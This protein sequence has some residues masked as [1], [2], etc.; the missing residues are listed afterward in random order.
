[1]TQVA[2]ATFAEVFAAALRGTPAHVVGLHPADHPLPVDG[3]SAAAEA[4]D[5]TLLAHCLGVTLDLGCGPGRM[6]GHLSAQGQVVL[7]IDIVPAAVDS[8]RRRGDPAQRLRP[9]SR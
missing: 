8:T 3:W 2:I 7:G 5:R 4:S 1:M 6:S 9:A